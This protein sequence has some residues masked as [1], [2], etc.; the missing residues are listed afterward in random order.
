MTLFASMPSGAPKATYA[1]RDT[2]YNT[3]IGNLD[4]VRLQIQARLNPSPPAIVAAVMARPATSSSAIADAQKAMTDVPSLGSVETMKHTMDV[5][6]NT[7]SRRGLSPMLV[8]GF[9]RRFEISME[10]ALVYEKALNR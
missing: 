8:D 6:R 9:R 4:A 5:M 2:A 10:Q 7:D 1:K 3:I